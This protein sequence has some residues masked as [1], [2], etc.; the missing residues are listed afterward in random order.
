MNNLLGA[1]AEETALFESF[2]QRHQV[3]LKT[4]FSEITVS[5]NSKLGYEESIVTT[6]LSTQKKAS[7]ERST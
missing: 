6:L 2:I 5:E 4:G 3:F 1:S 7:I